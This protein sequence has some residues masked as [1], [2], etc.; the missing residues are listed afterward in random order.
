MAA[1]GVVVDPTKEGGSGMSPET[2]RAIQDHLASRMEHERQG[3]ALDWSGKALAFMAAAEDAID[4]GKA[5]EAE[6]LLK[7]SEAAPDCVEA[8]AWCVL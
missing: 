5:E 7:M 2:E 1:A 6:K 8:M 4:A 3:V